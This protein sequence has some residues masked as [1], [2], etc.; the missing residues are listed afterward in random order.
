MASTKLLSKQNGR[1][2]VHNYAIY[3]RW[4]APPNVAIES[5]KSP[6][7]LNTNGE[8]VIKYRVILSM[9]YVYSEFLTFLTFR[10]TFWHMRFLLGSF[11]RRR[12]SFNVL[13]VYMFSSI[14]WVSVNKVQMHSCDVYVL[15]TTRVD[16]NLK[17]FV[18]EFCLIILLRACDAWDSLGT[19]PWHITHFRG[20][21][22]TAH[23]T[24]DWIEV[25]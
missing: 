15:G 21:F 6:F 2:I 3:R 1:G 8:N 5:F 10:T 19:L 12:I 7:T 23:K 14:S 22:Q 13:W 24:A 25:E 9:G 17:F 20:R 16:A 4:N 18:L 11:A